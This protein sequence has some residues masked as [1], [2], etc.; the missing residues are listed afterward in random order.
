M[1]DPRLKC[2]AEQLVAAKEL[3]QAFLY[4]IDTQPEEREF[5][6]AILL[7][8]G[9]LL[10]GEVPLAEVRDDQLVEALNAAEIAE[11]QVCPS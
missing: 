1:L 3:I 9:A 8:V 5:N 11:K 7:R 6:L 4:A 10:R 2:S